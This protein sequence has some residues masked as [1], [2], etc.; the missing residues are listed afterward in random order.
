MNMKWLGQYLSVSAP[1]ERRKRLHG[2]A[3]SGRSKQALERVPW[4]QKT[5]HGLERHIEMAWR[6]ARYG[7]SDFLTEEWNRMAQRMEEVGASADEISALRWM[8]DRTSD[9]VQTTTGLQSPTPTVL[10]QFIASQNPT[11]RSDQDLQL[12]REQAHRLVQ[13]ATVQVVSADQPYSEDEQCSI[14]LK[15]YEPKES[16]RKLPCT[17]A[18]H[19]DCLATWLCKSQTCPLCREVIRGNNI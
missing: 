19:G 9:S 18:F 1:G 5:A 17:H 4:R 14:C 15:Q 8:Q 11:P 16:H 6:A 12:S 7:Y 10:E 3:Y 2:R 13:T